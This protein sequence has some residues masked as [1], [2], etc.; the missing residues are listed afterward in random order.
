MLGAMLGASENGVCVPE[1]QFVINVYKKYPEV[2]KGQVDKKHLLASMAKDIRFRLWRLDSSAI[3]KIMD[4]NQYNFS[5]ILAKIV[6]AYS[7]KHGKPE[8]CYWVDHTPNNIKNMAILANIFPTAKFI[9]IVRDGRA[10]AAS[11][12]KTIWGPKTAHAA[13]RY[14][15]EALA[16]CFSAQVR[17]GHKKILS[18]RYEDI[19]ETPETCLR[20]ICQFCGIAYDPQ[21]ALG[22]DFKPALQKTDQHRLVGRPP[23]KQRADSWKREMGNRQVEIFENIAGEVLDHL[24]YQTAYW[25]YA[26]PIRGVERYLSGTKEVFYREVI[27]RVKVSQRFKREFT[28]AVN[29]KVGERH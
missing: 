7:E 24:G 23:E 9:H 25:P 2:M 11:L 16:Y 29:K 13:A 17:Y 18:V 6:L 19:L 5:D 20:H 15:L 3:Q 27:N 4:G 22:G 21:M 14:W 1:A 26:R 28:P 8:P 10:V 12:V